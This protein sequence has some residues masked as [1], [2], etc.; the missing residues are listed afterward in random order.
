[1]LNMKEP[2]ISLVLYIAC[3]NQLD[4]LSEDGYLS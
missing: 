4:L 1:M 2:K 3:K